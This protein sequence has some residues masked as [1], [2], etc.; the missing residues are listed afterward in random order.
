ME[1]NLSLALTF[2]DVLLRPSYSGFDRQDITLTTSL[3][4]RIQLRA[5]IVSSPMDTVTE[6]KMAIALA[7]L[8]G[9][10]FIHRN[11]TIEK[12]V[13][14]VKKVKK[15]GL[16]V[17]AAVGS[18]AGYEVRVAELV[19][20]GADVLIIDSA[21]GY[22]KK[23]IQAVKYVKANFDIEVIA[24]NVATAEGAEALIDAGADALRVGMGPG[25][26]CSTRIISG[27]GV[28]QLTALFET[29]SVAQQHG[30]PVIADGGISRSG[31]IVKAL[32]AGASTVMLG[33]LLAATEESPGKVVKLKPEHVPGRFQNIIDGSAE[34]TFKEYRGMGSI[35]AMKQGLKI[36]SEDEFHGKDYRGD[37]LV[38]EGVEGLV[39]CSGTLE[40]LLDQLVGGI[41]SGMY[42]VGARTIPE[43]WKT[44]RFMRITQASLTESHPHDLFITNPGDNYK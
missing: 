20:A 8:G 16:L 21:H 5:P 42:Y 7:C 27:M 31:D 22:S 28:P 36:S 41:Y 18:S 29:T 39:P 9:V 26:I 13:A 38:A 44:A 4:K 1:H 32:A 37:T 23:V 12:Q 6:S 43:L 35:S 34:Y 14:E 25:A 19:K 17:G 10:G 40:Q 24:G 15:E 3:T 2:D 33:R 30:V 11:L